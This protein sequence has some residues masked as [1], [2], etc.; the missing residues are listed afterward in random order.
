MKGI[1]EVKEH[2][3]AERYTEQELFNQYGYLM[4]ENHEMDIELL[5]DILEETGVEVDC[6]Y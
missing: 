6:I 5:V 3:H 2:G 4:G 1:Y